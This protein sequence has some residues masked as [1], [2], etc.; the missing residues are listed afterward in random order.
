MDKFDHPLP[1][2]INR[3]VRAARFSLVVKIGHKWRTYALFEDYPSACEGL[4]F[5]RKRYPD[6][7]ADIHQ[8]IEF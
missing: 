8:L 6:F 4:S 2:P 1:R 3:F 7:F 5:F